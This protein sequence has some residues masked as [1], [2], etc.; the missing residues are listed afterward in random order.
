[1]MTTPVHNPDPSFLG[2]GLLRPVARPSGKSR[3]P[4]LTAP[5]NFALRLRHLLGVSARAE[6]VRFLL[7][8]NAPRASVAQYRLFRV[9]QAQRR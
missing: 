5:I 6:A 4:D 2:Q 8:T 3:Q 9:Q 1:M 7:T